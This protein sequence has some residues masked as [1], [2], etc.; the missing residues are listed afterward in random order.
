[1]NDEP[2]PEKPAALSALAYVAALAIHPLLINGANAIAGCA[3]VAG[4]LLF[5]PFRL[6]IRAFLIAACFVAGLVRA[7]QLESG[8]QADLDTLARI[9]KDQFVTVTG[10]VESEWSRTGEHYQASLIR[11]L[12]TQGNR[13][14]TLHS[15]LRIFLSDSPK[16]LAHE[17]HLRA[18]GFLRRSDRGS[19]HLTVKTSRLISY[20]G[21]QPPWN[22]RYWNREIGSRLDR[23][24]E[25]PYADRRAIALVKAIALGRTEELPAEVRES[26]RRGGTYHL[27]VFSGMQITFAAGFV[28]FFF[29]LISL[30]RAADFLLLSA[31]VAAPFFAGSEPSVS[32]ASWMIGLYA[33]ARIL[34]RPT[35]T[36][37][38][39]FVSALIRLAVYPAE[40]TD[41][42]FALTYAAAGGLILVGKPLARRM[43][44]PLVLLVFG[45][46]A[47]VAITPL[48]LFF[49]HQYVAAG[50][51]VTALLAPIVALMFT[52]SVVV[53]LDVLIGG[54]A[55]GPLLIFVSGLHE[56]AAQLN[57][58]FGERL[59]LSGVAASPPLAI[60]V[61]TYFTY[62]SVQ[63]LSR[64]ARVLGISA[65]LL[66]V[67]VVV[68][69]HHG[70]N[71][72]SDVSELKLLDV[73]Q[74]ESILLR[75]PRGSML[76]DGG[77]RSG[78]E[79]FGRR[80]LL[81]LLLES[82]TRRLEV[83]AV[84]HAHPDHCGGLP[85]I[86]DHLEVGELWI[87][88]RQ[89]SDGCVAELSHQALRRGIRVRRLGHR[90]A[91]STLGLTFEPLIGRLK[92]KRSA[93]NNGSLV[94]RTSIEGHPILL[95]GDIEKDAE[96]LL[97]S[98][99]ADRLDADILKIAHHGS[100]SSSTASFLEAV[101]P[102]IAL[103]S[104]GRRNLFGHPSTE[105]IE[106]IKSLG[107]SL[108]RTDTHGT[109]TITFRKGRILV[110]RE[111]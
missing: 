91:V 14:S 92:F 102:R 61:I 110:T 3:L 35:S 106:R 87:S 59:G 28:L 9:N 36:E 74:G 18:E 83:V 13:S 70:F 2:V 25:E 62:V 100:R 103:V 107:A 56:T 73:G 54:F 77:G 75:T 41:A 71:S 111:N 38:L 19:Y 88:A 67:P 105:V 97:V 72:S 43:K 76:I 101:S 45:M 26:Y 4:I 98:E 99:D 23:L 85:A 21:S 5:L 89:I 49:L 55:T 93:S 108:Y 60:I 65:L 47:E 57:V 109:L 53:C 16:K 48:T 66:L 40:I 46:G 81:P 30:P 27:L 17:S 52:V 10:L 84:T 8:T 94:L 34:R 86:L 50:F 32:R 12:I 96:R 29:R 51:V 79:A 24:A 11:P 22:P 1:M 31:A 82:G 39:L 78:D 42:G 15:S 33:L 58:F 95:T 80:V 44:R 104:C 68:V 7:G 69:I 63:A 90:R 20:L 37:N 64:S 6:R